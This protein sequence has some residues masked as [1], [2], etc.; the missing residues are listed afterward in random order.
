MKNKIYELQEKEQ[1]PDMSNNG[2]GSESKIVIRHL[3]IIKKNS[4]DKG[5][6]MNQ[7]ELINELKND[8]K[9]LMKN[10][11]TLKKKISEGVKLTVKDM[12]FHE[13]KI[14]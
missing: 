11:D 12:V 2:E 10:L 13:P 8:N 6:D 9:E 4:I 1:N 5:E 14:S 3:P 7:I